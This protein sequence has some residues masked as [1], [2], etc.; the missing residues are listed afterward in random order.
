MAH[1]FITTATHPAPPAAPADTVAARNP[2]TRQALRA[3]ELDL[4]EEERRRLARDLHDEA[5][6]RLTAAV[7]QLDVIARQHGQNP[8]LQAGLEAARHL[9]QECADGLHDVAFD[10]RP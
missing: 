3:H 6:H 9:I 10:L 4:L 8:E 1:G 2:R 5:G 7:L